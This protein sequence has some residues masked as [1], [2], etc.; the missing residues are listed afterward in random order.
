MQ[1]GGKQQQFNNNCCGI[2][3][4][5]QAE[6]HTCGGTASQNGFT[7]FMELIKKPDKSRDKPFKCGICRKGFTLKAY[8]NR[9]LLAPEPAHVDIDQTFESLP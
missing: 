4:D 7:N 9:H 3:N 8:L 2:N 5:S 6:V 1:C